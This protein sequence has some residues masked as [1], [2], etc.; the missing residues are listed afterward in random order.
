MQTSNRPQPCSC[1]TCS[2]Q[3]APAFDALTAWFVVVAFVL[4]P[5]RALV[6]ILWGA[7]Q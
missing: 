1:P 5:G 7:M 3:T 2:P 4:I 6:Q